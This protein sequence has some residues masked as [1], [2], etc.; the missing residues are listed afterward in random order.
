M[1]LQTRAEGL[2]CADPG[3]RTPIGISENFGILGKMSKFTLIK[4]Y[5][6]KHGLHAFLCLYMH[7][8][9]LLVEWWKITKKLNSRTLF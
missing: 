9:F 4:K 6:H 3:V 1:T 5:V 8:A 7:A 2:T